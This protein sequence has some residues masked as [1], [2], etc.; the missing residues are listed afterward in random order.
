MIVGMF[1]TFN[2]NFKA[3]PYPMTGFACIAQSANLWQNVNFFVILN[4]VIDNDKLTTFWTT[5]NHATIGREQEFRYYSLL[6][7]LKQQKIML[8]IFSNLEFTLNSLL[9]I[10]LLFSMRR[11]FYP[12]RMRMKEIYL[13][14]IVLNSL[15]I[16]LFFN[17][18][19]L[20]ESLPKY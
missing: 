1:I 19:S 17:S 2:P 16:I 8:T 10:D 9:V 4:N 14:I 3:H 6:R 5:L 11:P 18:N 13:F 15:L 12:R 20:E 7:I